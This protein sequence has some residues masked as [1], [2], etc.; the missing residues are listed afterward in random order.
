MGSDAQH[1][2]IQAVTKCIGMILQRIPGICFR[3]RESYMSWTRFFDT[4][5]PE[6][7]ST[8][9]LLHDDVLTERLALHSHLIERG[10]FDSK[11]H[12]IRTWFESFV[13]QSF[14]Y[15]ADI[16]AQLLCVASLLGRETGINA[17]VTGALCA[18]ASILEL[19][20]VV[21]LHTHMLDW[22]WSLDTERIPNASLLHQRLVEAQARLGSCLFGSANT[23][24]DNIA[25]AAVALLYSE[26]EGNESSPLCNIYMRILAESVPFI[27]CTKVLGIAATSLR[28]DPFHTSPISRP[29]SLA[30]IRALLTHRLA[31]RLEPA[32]LSALG[33]TAGGDTKAYEDKDAID[34]VLLCIEGTFSFLEPSG[35][36]LTSVVSGMRGAV[37]D[38][39]AQAVQNAFDPAEFDDD[40][41]WVFRQRHVRALDFLCRVFELGLAP[42]PTFRNTFIS[43]LDLRHAVLI[44]ENGS[45][46]AQ[47]ALANWVSI[48]GKHVPKKMLS[49][50]VDVLTPMLR[51][52]LTGACGNFNAWVVYFKRLVEHTHGLPVQK[53]LLNGRWVR[54]AFGC[55]C[56]RNVVSAAGSRTHHPPHRTT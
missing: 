28:Q 15:S 1:K 39:A 27:S 35:H 52:G 42:T 56:A 20:Q 29:S 54:N 13:S 44:S 17:D 6:T 37:F 10:F 7:Y 16:A 9:A 45:L 43:L 26:S 24:S 2:T 23:P 11:L 51:Y 5:N 19:K 21:Q 22:I 25:R 4:A 34:Q 53:S 8:G 12:Q 49:A 38:I 33:R 55:A 46:I 3:N 14:Q 47:K 36:T 50:F 48:A 30:L 40:K 31:P 18:R 41:Q 32:V